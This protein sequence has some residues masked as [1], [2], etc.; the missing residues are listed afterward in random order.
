MIEE[1]DVR[2]TAEAMAAARRAKGFSRTSLAASAGI[3]LQ[4]IRSYETGRNLPGQGKSQP[5]LPCPW[6]EP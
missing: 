5:D 2:K 3:G 6:N 1:I 4:S